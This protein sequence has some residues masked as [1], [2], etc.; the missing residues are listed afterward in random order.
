MSRK[1]RE[2]YSNVILRILYLT[3]RG[4]KFN[5]GGIGIQS[6]QLQIFKLKFSEMMA[7]KVETLPYG[8]ILCELSVQMEQS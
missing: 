3:G 6:Y 8:H 7:Q 4:F 2:C 1:I 5:F